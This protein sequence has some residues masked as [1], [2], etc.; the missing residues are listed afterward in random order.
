VCEG[1]PWS[2][3]LGSPLPSKGSI[4]Q[5]HSFLEER[6]EDALAG[7]PAGIPF[8]T[9]HE[10]LPYQPWKLVPRTKM[11]IT[12]NAELEFDSGEGA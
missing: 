9:L 10:F 5:L 6:R 1:A 3:V 4:P 11:A 8:A 12:G 2:E 7:V